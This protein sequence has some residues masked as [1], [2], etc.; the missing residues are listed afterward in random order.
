[1]N[2]YQLVLA[3]TSIYRRQLLEKLKIPFIT[4]SPFFDETPK[5]H[6]SPED[7][8]K[9]L[10]EG[11]ARSC[12]IDTPS[13]IIGSDQVCVVNNKI[14]GKP[15]TREHAI[16]QLS[17]Q[18]GQRVSFYTG[19]TLFNNE[20]QTFHTHVDIFHVHFRTLTIQQI[21]NYVDRE[22]PLDC[23]GSFK[24]EGLGI[25][26]FERLEGDDPNALIGLPLIKLV[27]MLE[28]A[29]IPVL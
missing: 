9:R 19:L 15:G 17:E 23:A 20:S 26:L 7:L 5:A 25:A 13:L 24:S 22:Q 27:R 28:Q 11:K 21:E 29:G 12:H 10:A 2:Q 3:S 18:S 14:T 1:M 4:A 16:T 8:V 6:E